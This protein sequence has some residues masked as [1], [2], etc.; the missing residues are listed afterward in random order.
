MNGPAVF[1][2]PWSFHQISDVGHQIDYMIDDLQGAPA[3]MAQLT[4][5]LAV[6]ALFE[7]SDNVIEF[8]PNTSIELAVIHVPQLFER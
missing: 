2:V 7:L 8:F 5:L 6:A 3:E 4:A 1:E